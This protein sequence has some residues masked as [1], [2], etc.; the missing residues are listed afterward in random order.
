MLRKILISC[1][2]CFSVVADVSA[3]PLQVGNSLSPIE[4]KT[5]HD[6]VVKVR[7][8]V[9]TLLFAVEKAPSDLV[10]KF[11]VKQDPN[12]LI[13]SKAYFIADISGMPSMITKMFAIPK[14]KKLPYE[15]LLVKSEKQLAF[16][17]RKKNF[18]TVVKPKFLS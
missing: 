7:N 11:L 17:P 5:Q 15:I 3:T 14:M 12:F 1:L 16:M 9:K 13:A 8:D 18:V 4:L 10:N 2:L 6:K